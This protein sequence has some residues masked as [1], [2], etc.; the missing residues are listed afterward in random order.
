MSFDPA[1]FDA[2]QAMALARKTFEIEAAAV[3]GLA[4]RVGP[5]FADAVKLMLA[6]RGRVVVMG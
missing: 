5:Q 4:A 6:C 3:L 2:G 1:T